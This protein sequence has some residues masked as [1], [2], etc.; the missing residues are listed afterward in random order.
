MAQV[1]GQSLTDQDTSEAEAELAA[2]EAALEPELP[3]VPTAKVGGG[4]A[5]GCSCG[6]PLLPA[7][8]D[9]GCCRLQLRSAAAACNCRRWVLPGLPQIEVPAKPEQATAAAAEVA[10]AA[11]EEEEEEEEEAG[12]RR[13][14]QPLAA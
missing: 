3:S 1:L 7:I 9:A 13:L 4:G 10:E 5:A 8:A 11:A 12:S 2:L 14:E 6:P